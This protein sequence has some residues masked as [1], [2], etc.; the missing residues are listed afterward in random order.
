MQKRPIT[1]KIIIQGNSLKISARKQ[2]K[3]NIIE[4]G[5]SRLKKV[6]NHIAQL[7]SITNANHK[8]IALPFLESSFNEKAISKVNAAGAWQIM[9]WIG[10]KLLPYLEGQNRC[11]I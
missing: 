7:F 4:G 5:L 2:V 3:K 11:P 8:W 9:P 10:K 6:E 1:R